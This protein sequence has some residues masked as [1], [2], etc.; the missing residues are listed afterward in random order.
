MLNDLPPGDPR[1]PHGTTQADIDGRR[2]CFDDGD[3]I[4]NEDVIL[5]D[6]REAL[7]HKATVICYRYAQARSLEDA[8]EHFKATELDLAIKDERVIDE[9]FDSFGETEVEEV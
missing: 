9:V 4:T 6:Y 3:C 1:L 8:K 2:P 7:K 5:N